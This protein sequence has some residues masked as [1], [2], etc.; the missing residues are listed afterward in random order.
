MGA[1]VWPFSEG[2]TGNELVDNVNQL[3]PRDIPELMRQEMA[4]DIILD[5]LEG[6]VELDQIEGTL[7]TYRS[8][9]LR[10]SAPY[11]SFSIDRPIPG[12]HDAYY[13]DIIAA[14]WDLP[15]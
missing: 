5:L 10:S 2:S 4:Q 6:T 7:S 13:R 12:T 8:R 1:Q 15:E 11:G 3:L 9:A 14:P